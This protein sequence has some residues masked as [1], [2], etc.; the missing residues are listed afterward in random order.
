MLA[1]TFGQWWTPPC[2]VMTFLAPSTSVTTYLLYKTSDCINGIRYQTVWTE[3]RDTVMARKNG[4]ATEMSQAVFDVSGLVHGVI[5]DGLHK[6]TRQAVHTYVRTSAT[7][8]VLR[9]SDISEISWYRDRMFRAILSDTDR[10]NGI[11]LDAVHYNLRP[12][13]LLYC[14]NRL[15]RR[16]LFSSISCFFLLFPLSTISDR[17]F[18]VAMPCVWN[19]L[20]DWLTLTTHHKLSFLHNF[21]KHLFNFTCATWRV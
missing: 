15:N 19:S 21:E 1:C 10:P 20:P 8:C 12:T 3:P 6:C 18:A 5:D 14:F 13:A 7:N 4:T 9:Q 17:A 16:L 11:D 2:A